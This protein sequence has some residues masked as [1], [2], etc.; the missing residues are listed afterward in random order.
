MNK[1]K[2]KYLCPND[3]DHPSFH[4]FGGTSTLMGW[5]P[6]YDKQG[7]PLNANPN[8]KEEAFK[9]SVC[10]AEARKRTK[11]WRITFIDNKTGDVYHEID[12]TPDY[13]KDGE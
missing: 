11:C 5:T 7:R 4:S 13:L 1:E 6:K 9:C 12:N 8:T 10:G 2:I 3:K